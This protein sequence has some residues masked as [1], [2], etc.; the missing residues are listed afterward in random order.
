MKINLFKQ[1][2]LAIFVFLFML[3]TVEAYTYTFR[4]TAING[5]AYD[6]SQTYQ[7]L[8]S[9]ITVGG[10]TQS[11]TAPGYAVNFNVNSNTVY[12]VRYV[13][14]GF[15]TTIDDIY[16][17]TNLPSCSGTTCSLSSGSFNTACT[18]SSTYSDWTCIVTD[19]TTSQ[20][21]SFVYNK[22]DPTWGEVIRIINSM[23]SSSNNHAPVANNVNVAT[24]ED[25]P[26]VVTFNCTDAD[27]DPLTYSVLTNPASGNLAGSGN[28]RTYTPNPNYNGAD[29]FTYRCNDGAVNSNT[30]TVS[31]TVNAVNDTPVANNDAYSINEDTVL[32]GNILTNDTDVDGNNLTA[33]LVSN[34]AHGVLV[35]NANGSFT[36]TPNLNYNGTDS[37]TYVANDGAANSSIATV[38]VNVIPVNDAPVAQNLNVTTDEDVPVNITLNCTGNNLTYSNLNPANGVLTGTSPNLVYTPNQNF[39]GNDS[40][41]YRCYDGTVYSNL[42][43]VSITV[44]LVNDAP[45]AQNDSYS[46][47]EDTLLNGNVLT[48]DSDTE[49]DNLTS[50]LVSNVTNGI[51]V[52]N[53][54]GSFVY[55]PNLNFNGNDSFIYVANDGTA[56]SSAATVTINVVATNDAPVAENLNV[57]T[58]EDS[59]VNITLNCT[60]ADGDSLTYNIVRNVGHGSLIGS[61]ENRTYTPNANYNGADNFNY[62]CSDGSDYSN[63]A[64]VSITVNPVNDLPIAN[65]NNYGTNEDVV[66]NVN[67]TLG[68]LANDVDVDGD[69]LTAILVSNVANGNLTLNS[70]GSFVYTPNLNF[71]GNDSFTYV[72]N[73]GIGNSSAAT[74]TITVNAINDAPVAQNLN[75]TT[76][77]DSSV[78]IT[79]N[80][81]DAEG[82]SLTYSLSTPLPTNGILTGTGQ[83]RTYIPDA[84]YNGTDSFN[85]R[86]ND[87]SDYSN[88]AA[89]SITII[90]VNDIPTATN[91]YYNAIQNITLNI[92]VPGVLGNDNDPEGSALSSFIVTNPSNGA[93]TLNLNGSFSYTPGLG[94][95]GIDTFTYVA[96]DGTLN[97]SAAT[98]TINVSTVFVN[99][100]PVAVNDTYTTL[101]DTIL[102]INA[103][104]I[105]TNDYDANIG[106]NL[107][108]ILISNVANGN[109][110]LNANGSFVYT[111]N[112]NFNG[113]DSFTY[114]AN[115]GTD[116]ST[117]TG[118]RIIV[119]PV[120]DAPWNNATIPDVTFDEDN[121]N[122]SLYLRNYFFDV[123]FDNL[124]YISECNDTDVIVIINNV[125][126]NANFSATLNWFGNASCNFTAFDAVNPSNRS[127]P[128]T[129]IVS[130][131][132]DAPIAYDDNI[133]TNEDTSILI[134]VTANDFDVEGYVFVEGIVVAPLHGTAVI[135]NGL[136]NYTPAL[137]YYGTDSL[138]YRINDTGGLQ[139]AAVVDIT[140]LSV[141]DLPYNNATIPD[142]A[143]NEDGYND[144]LYLRN[145]FFDVEFDNLTYISECNDT[146]NLIVNINNVTSNVNF[147]A[148]LDWFGS[149]ECNFTAYEMSN[150]S[151]RSNPVRVLVN[152][153]NDLPIANDDFATTA[154]DTSILINVTA[155]DTDV[156][157]PLALDS[158]ITAPL[159]GTATIQNGSVNYT[160]N[161]DYFGTDNFTYRVND[162]DGAQTNA[163]VYITIT[164]AAE[165]PV[166]NP[167]G[168][169]TINE[170]QNLNFVVNATDGDGDN[171]TYMI[172][173]TPSGA[174]F[175][176]QLFNWTPNATQNGTYYVTFIVSDGV[177]ED[178]ETIMIN[179]VDSMGGNNAPI[180][181][182]IGNFAINETQNLNFV[183]NATD[184]DGD[185]LT[186]NVSGLPEGATFAGQSFNWTPN[187]TQGGI[188]N[189]T[190]TV[191]DGSLSDSETVIITVGNF[192]MAPILSPIG[193]QVASE[194]VTLTFTIT[195]TDANGDVLTY[196]V[197]GLPTGASFNATTQTFTWTP[198]SVQGGIYT[199]ITFTVSD[200]LL[201]DSESINITVGNTIN[202]APYITSTPITEAIPK[203]EYV[204]DVNAADLDG[205]VLTYSLLEGPSGM[206]INSATGLIT[207]TPG[208]NDEGN[209]IVTVMVSDGSL[210]DT[211]SFTVT[212]TFPSIELYPRQKIYIDSI[213]MNNEVYDVVEPG[214]D[215]FINVGYDNMGVY[216]MKSSIRVTVYELGIS[217]KIGPFNGP[218]SSDY[219]NEMVPLEIPQD[220]QPGVYTLRMSLYDA[221]GN[222]KRTKHRDFRV[223]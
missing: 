61:L 174:T 92:T 17:D 47:N 72:A 217:R 45:V 155:N 192:N 73:D 103:P 58:N 150:P 35:L 30:A 33:I 143:F 210:N 102:N 190:F 203:I 222:L 86:C 133:T 180:L 110:T 167:I 211:Q 130:A 126:S 29:S 55:T 125:T 221:E 64:V 62:T 127:N 74:V 9:S 118:V 42:A 198:T 11:G 145:Y 208:A 184:P 156:E 104:G 46:V 131:V 37:F 202:N 49:G 50:I 157:G 166:L 66:L 179:V 85:Y 63:L 162:T 105:L 87:A 164:S 200:G 189:V 147:T 223:E 109:L 7:Y 56:N 144:S 1:L 91:D 212:S 120:N 181:N 188:Y 106:D 170:T 12:N 165:A 27:G 213:M 158:I 96:N 134:N 185:N 169:F 206:T 183:V 111:P 100:P 95:T 116:N 13:S 25:A 68:V 112:L 171:L 53:A 205:D 59:S 204:Y 90:G 172:I 70:N 4:T 159:Y 3:S 108:A 195:A 115:D 43:N 39:N 124:T 107:T 178:N 161:A 89:V 99:T 209:F 40:F 6:L 79:L 14:S 187:S 141:N 193:N 76:N 51:L 151:N 97:S 128:V 216:D 142:V 121:Y 83:N 153:V 19:T 15:I 32:N 8:P 140:I 48:N 44:N 114:V 136:I 173:G 138:V 88:I 93:V 28:S 21:I 218:D 60:D 123:E 20:W 175:A 26:F 163:T 18:Y 67:T 31:I 160:P 65:N 139:D 199:N 52:L 24:P 197:S 196:N 80:C 71:N 168:N 177:L 129:V 194:N 57:T 154:E 77:E 149:A 94:F 82:D 81:S 117:V 16:F 135:Q 220:A 101:E 10:V 23:Y 176:G 84:N 36:Y 148:V 98:V 34:V 41:V 191:S 122:D 215:L 5:T 137:N 119:T 186:Y 69:N 75:I 146:T 22:D 54:N 78:N 152:A 219:A 201:T 132:N 207:W 182:P 2:F 38:N 113:A 214:D